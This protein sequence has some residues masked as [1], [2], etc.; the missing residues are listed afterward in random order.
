MSW[1]QL[2]AAFH[3]LRKLNTMRKARTEQTAFC[4]IFRLFFAN[5]AL[6]FHQTDHIEFLKLIKIVI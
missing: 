3:D 6:S 5:V 4:V 1:S 2:N